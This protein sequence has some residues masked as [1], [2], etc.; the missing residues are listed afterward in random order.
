M[1]KIGQ[2]PKGIRAHLC[3]SLF[4]LAP[5]GSSWLLL[6]PT[7]HEDSNPTMHN[8]Y[9]LKCTKNIKTSKSIVP[10]PRKPWPLRLACVVEQYLKHGKN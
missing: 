8:Y 5:P 6:A 3:S 2:T 1:V 4:L 10:A 9:K 7:M